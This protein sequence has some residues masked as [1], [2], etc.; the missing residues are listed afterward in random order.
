MRL[1][2][3]PSD[4]SVYKDGLCYSNLIWQGTPNNIHALQ[5]FDNNGW[6]ELTDSINQS[7]TELPEWAV[8]ALNSWE[9]NKYR[10]DAELAIA[11]SQPI[12]E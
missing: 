6:I 12:T 3:I 5:W 10:I 1:T 4:K 8:N 2:I 11:I 7:I 9:N